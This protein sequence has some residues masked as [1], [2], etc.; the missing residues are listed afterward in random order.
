[1]KK[2]FLLS[3]SLGYTTKK[4]AQFKLQDDGSAKAVQALGAVFGEY[5]AMFK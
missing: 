1:M 5:Y 4:P 3:F 2:I